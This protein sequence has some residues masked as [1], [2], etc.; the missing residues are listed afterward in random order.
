MPAESTGKKKKHAIQTLKSQ[1]SDE[2]GQGFKMDR[3]LL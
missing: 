2:R 3:T 1:R